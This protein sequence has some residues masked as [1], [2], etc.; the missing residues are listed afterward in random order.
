M[1]YFCYTVFESSPLKEV[2]YEALYEVSLRCQSEVC[3]QI[4][5]I[6]VL[7]KRLPKIQKR[8]G[9]TKS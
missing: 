3:P 5:Q 1:C 8:E 9:V 6:L 4:W 2:H 7:S